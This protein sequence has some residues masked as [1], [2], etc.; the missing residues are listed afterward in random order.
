MDMILLLL[1]VLAEWIIDDLK[2][3]IKMAMKVWSLVNSFDQ[4]SHEP[5]Q[6]NAS[7]GHCKI[8]SFDQMRRWKSS[9][10]G[11]I[12]QFPPRNQKMEQI[13]DHESQIP[14]HLMQ[15]TLLAQNVGHELVPTTGQDVENG[16]AKK[17]KLAM[18]F[19]VPR[20][21][22]GNEVL[23]GTSKTNFC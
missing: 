22:T 6:K 19:N 15:L 10:L 7:S 1:W 16:N 12:F 11:Q 9:F 2:I 21:D 4:C 8:L 3:P 5:K 13:R 17:C 14:Q 23:W 20:T 18:I